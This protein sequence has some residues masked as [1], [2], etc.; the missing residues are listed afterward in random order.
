MGLCGEC[1]CRCCAKA[2]F[3]DFLLFIEN[4]P[5]SAKPKIGAD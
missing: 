5:K 4:A 1:N 2:S 3:S